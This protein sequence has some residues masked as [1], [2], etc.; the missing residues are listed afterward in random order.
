VGWGGMEWNGIVRTEIESK[1]V[2]DAYTISK[3]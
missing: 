1:D 3:L 2:E